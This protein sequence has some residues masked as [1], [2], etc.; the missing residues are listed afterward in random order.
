MS[1]YHSQVHFASEPHLLTVHVV[2]T[3]DRNGGWHHVI[4]NRK[5]FEERIATLEQRLSPFLKAGYRKKVLAH[6]D[7]QELM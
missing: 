7:D 5:R 2:G 4:R 3:E 1:F 6:R